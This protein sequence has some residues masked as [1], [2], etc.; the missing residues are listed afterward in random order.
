MAISK[1]SSSF[2]VI[3]PVSTPGGHPFVGETC[4]KP[5]TDVYL[6]DGKLVIKVEL[7]G[8]RREDLELTFENNR[9]TIS[10]HRADNCRSPHAKCR[11]LVME[12]NYGAFQSV[13]ELPAAFDLSKAQAAYQNGFLRIEVPESAGGAQKMPVRGR[14]DE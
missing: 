1:P 12:I 8:I 2:P 9:L 3:H 10:G 11:F 5:N 13:I 7:A 4:W 6:T 14:S